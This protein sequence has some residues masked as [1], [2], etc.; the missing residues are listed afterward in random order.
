MNKLFSKF[1][2]AGWWA[3]EAAL[4]VWLYSY[5]MDVGLLGA[6]RGFAFHT[7]VLW[8]AFA[9]LM[10]LKRHA[11]THAWPIWAVKLL[12]AM[13]V[14]AYIYDCWFNTRYGTLAFLE[15]PPARENQVLGITI[16]HRFEPFTSRLKRHY[17]IAG[18][19]G[20]EARLFCWLVHKVDKGHCL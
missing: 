20:N 8:L 10:L 16:K 4:L 17:P 14:P 19:R 7:A 2:S 3:S 12:R 11:E 1:F 15:F 13:F 5:V 9:A 18:W 6:L